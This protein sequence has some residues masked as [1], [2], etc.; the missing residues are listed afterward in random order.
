MGLLDLPTDNIPTKL[1]YPTTEDEV[2]ILI[3]AGIKPTDR[4]KV[5]LSGTTEQAL[6]AGY[7]RSNN[8]IIV[9]IDA[10]NAIKDG[11]VI[12]RA[13]KYIY[14]CDEV[15]PKYIKRI[16]TE[17]LKESLNSEG[18]SKESNDTDFSE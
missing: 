18:E 8:P 15:D 3:E 7:V 12:K 4:K 2:E 1:Y 9:E 17:K 13:N 14:L 11:Y 5:H 6:N 10:E 16:D